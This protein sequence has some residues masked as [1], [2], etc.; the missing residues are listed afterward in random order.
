[1]GTKQ[2]KAHVGLSILVALFLLCLCPTT[3]FGL[4]LT[5]E[6]NS[7]IADP[8]WPLGAVEVANL[9]TRA[10]FLEFASLGGGSFQ[11]LYRCRTTEAFNQALNAFAS[12][13]APRLELVLH[14]GPRF[15]YFF[16]QWGP[17]SEPEDPIHW[18]FTV[19]NPESWHRLHNR[20]N[21]YSPSGQPVPAPKLDVYIGGGPIT[22]QE[23]RVPA[24]LVVIDQ[25]AESAP[26]RPVGG[27]LLRGDV[28]DI[29]TG[30][31]IPGADIALV[32]LEEDENRPDAIRAK[33]D[34]LGSFQIEK[35]PRGRYE[36]VISADGYVSRRA[37]RYANRGTTYHEL[38]AE[39]ARP[40]SIEGRVTNLEGEPIAG[41][42]VYARSIL[43][44]D[45]QEYP[46]PDAEPAVTDAEGRFELHSLPIGFVQ[47]GCRVSSMRLAR[48]TRE[49]CEV[50]GKPI[51]LTMEGAG[52]VRGKVVDENGNVPAG[53]V[54]VEVRP[55]ADAIGKWGGTIRCE[56]DGSFEVT[57][58]PPDEYLVSSNPG[59]LITG[60]DPDAI[61]VSIEAGK[62][63]ELKIVHRPRSLD[64]DLLET[65]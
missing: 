37:G 60:L 13:R 2:T 57:G 42:E 56:A 59:L 7:P 33:A 1:M 28:F 23:V 22:W 43:G 8:G 36:V 26:V 3:C 50:P 38:V 49:I 27:G 65:R 58:V 55:V 62:T 10:A 30:K 17:P 64:P 48:P 14:D 12:I 47:V 29:C 25:R 54:Y 19:W 5:A 61:R 63:V 21:G 15:G 40:A 32:S 46:T 16:E 41:A 24:G 20:I 52:T 31:P 18:T 34:R 4:R 45:G 9:P 39:L 11:F 44:I 35:V 6:G 53:E 51:E